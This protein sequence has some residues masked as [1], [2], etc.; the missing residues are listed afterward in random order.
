MN[1]V[2]L[3]LLFLNPEIS[4]GISFNEC[5]QLWIILGL[6]GFALEIGKLDEVNTRFT[7]WEPYAR[8]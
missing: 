8:I 7:Q 6:V 1:K 3:N 4:I 5:F 2:R